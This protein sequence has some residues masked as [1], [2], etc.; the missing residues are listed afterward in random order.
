M[1]ETD[2]H[3]KLFCVGAKII[4]NFAG[5]ELLTKVFRKRKVSFVERFFAY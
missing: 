2:N 3:N 4:E 5:F 1:L